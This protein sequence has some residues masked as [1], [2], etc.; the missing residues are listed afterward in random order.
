ML[1]RK[2][3]TKKVMDNGMAYFFFFLFFFFIEKDLIA[4]KT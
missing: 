2:E 3:A 4:A 1:N